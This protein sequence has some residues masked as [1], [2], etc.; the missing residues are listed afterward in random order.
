M[1]QCRWT[2][3]FGSFILLPKTGGGLFQFYLKGSGRNGQIRTADLPLRRRPL[4][5]SELRPHLLFSLPTLEAFLADIVAELFAIEMN[6]SH[7]VIGVGD[8]F[9][10][11]WAEGRYAQ[12]PA[13]VRA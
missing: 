9:G 3:G 6:A 11:R 10:Q 1:W 5:P 2:N 8:G 7:V 12:D 13:T 4:Y